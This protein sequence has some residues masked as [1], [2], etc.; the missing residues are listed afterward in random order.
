MVGRGIEA[1]DCPDLRPPEP[2]SPPHQFTRQFI[3]ETPIDEALDYYQS[4]LE[5]TR[6]YADA[7]PTLYPLCFGLSGDRVKPMPEQL[8]VWFEADEPIPFE[9]LDTTY[10]PDYVWSRVVELRAKAVERWDDKVTIAHTGLGVGLQALSSLRTTQQL[11]YDL[12][13]VPHEV[14]GVSK[15]LTDVSIQQYEASYDIIKKSNRG[16]ANWAPLW[17]PERTHLHECDFSCMISPEMFERFVM[18]DLERCIRRTNH[19]FYHLD[20]E[21]AISHLDMLLSLENL[22]DT[23]A[24]TQQSLEETIAHALATLTPQDAR[25]WF[26]ASGYPTCQN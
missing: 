25:A 13:D 21:G 9:D 14:I 18:P 26:N 1:A 16:T 11:L 5:S 4:Q 12:V 19:A 3:S 10:D 15:E 6:Y 8:T 22:R 20:G 17:S 24:R 7:L 23:K 2:R